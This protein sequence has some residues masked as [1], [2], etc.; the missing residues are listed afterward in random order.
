MSEKFNSNN[1]EN[2]Q[3]ILNTQSNDYKKLLTRLKEISVI[4]GLLEK[5]YLDKL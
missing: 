5:Q 1:I 4:I 2:D 3:N